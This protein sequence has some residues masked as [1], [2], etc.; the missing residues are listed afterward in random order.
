M[1]TWYFYTQIL[2]LLYKYIIVITFNIDAEC[3]DTDVRLVDG[4]T[5]NDGR[6]EICIG[7]LWGSVCDDRWDVRDAT[8]VCRQLGYNGSKPILPL[9]ITSVLHTFQHLLL[10]QGTGFQQTF[11]CSFILVKLIVM[12]MK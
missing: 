11:H 1:Q 4:N 9:C 6:V 5:P 8:V 3:N 10:W 12:E 2:F 7:G